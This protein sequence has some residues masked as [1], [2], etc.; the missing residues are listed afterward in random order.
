M[1]HAIWIE[2]TDERVFDDSDFKRNEMSSTGAFGGTGRPTTSTSGDSQVVV[3]RSSHNESFERVRRMLDVA[4]VVYDRVRSW[5]GVPEW[6]CVWGSKDQWGLHISWRT[7]FSACPDSQHQSHFGGGFHRSND[8]VYGCLRASEIGQAL[9]VGM[10]GSASVS[11]EKQA[12][13]LALELRKIVLMVLNSRTEFVCVPV[14]WLRGEV[15][16]MLWNMA[17]GPHD[18][19]SESRGCRMEGGERVDD[20]EPLPRVSMVDLAEFVTKVVDEQSVTGRAV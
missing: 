5:S 14:A 20:V 7:T 11:E 19:I 8:C 13:I 1:V 9:D 16:R 15:F 6:Y 17:T 2:S 4:N 12:G 3:I 10:D 18:V